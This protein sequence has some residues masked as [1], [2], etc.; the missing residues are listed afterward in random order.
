M[1]GNI[2]PELSFG[3]ELLLIKLCR[4]SYCM[5]FP[6]NWL[7]PHSVVSVLSHFPNFILFL[8]HC[9]LR[10]FVFCVLTLLMYSLFTVHFTT[11]T[12]EPYTYCNLL[13]L[14]WGTYW[15][16]MHHIAV[17][18]ILSFILFS[19]FVSVFGFGSGGRWTQWTDWS[20]C[21]TECIQ[22]RRRTCIDVNYD[23]ITTSPAVS[24]LSLDGNE[25]SACNGRDLQT[26]DCRGGYCNIGKEG[27]YTQTSGLHTC[28]MLFWHPTTFLA[29][30]MNHFSAL[31]FQI[32]VFIGLN[33][34][35]ARRPRTDDHSCVDAHS[36]RAKIF[37]EVYENY[38]KLWI[39]C[40]GGCRR[41]ETSTGMNK[42]NC[43]TM[44][45]P[46]FPDEKM[47]M[48][49]FAW[50]RTSKKWIRFSESTESC[51]S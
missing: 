24:K 48:N 33:V 17:R 22:I 35:S 21:T 9:L 27:K 18:V 16:W 29:I 34:N 30:S 10:R 19:F 44:E 3:L 51:P 46:F 14:L 6:S 8:P 32:S 37:N 2:L 15:I 31:L 26:R 49:I 36:L 7:S 39:A 13:L 12:I 20:T 40:V 5:V 41:R 23:S 28:D 43:C 1:D 45:E 38:Y 25:K 50:T 11:A 47:M 42:R 4:C